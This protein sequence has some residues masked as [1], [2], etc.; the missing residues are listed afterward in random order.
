MKTYKT[1]AELCKVIA[2]KRIYLWAGGF[3]V[4]VTRKALLN[5]LTGHAALTGSYEISDG[6]IRISAA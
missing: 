5:A 4:Q 3:F 2:G 1:K 6:V